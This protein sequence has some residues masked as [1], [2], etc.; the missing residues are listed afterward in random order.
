MNEI[1]NHAWVLPRPGST[2]IGSFPLHFEDKLLKLLKINPEHHKILHPFGGKAK[3]GIRVD[4]NATVEPDYIC[5]AQELPFDDEEFDCIICLDGNSEITLSNGKCCKIKNVKVGD[6]VISDSNEIGSVTNVYKR[7][8]SGK[9]TKLKIKGDFREII[10]TEKHKFL[11]IKGDNLYC[12]DKTGKKSRQ[13]VKRKLIEQ[14]FKPQ[15]IESKDLIIGDYLLSPINSKLINEIYQIKVSNFI[16]QSNYHNVSKLLPESIKVN[17]SFMR[18]IGYYCAEGDSGKYR[19]GFTFNINEK[20]YQKEI[21]RLTKEIYNLD[22][23]V[24]DNPISNSTYIKISSVNLSRFIQ[25]LVPNKSPHRKL[26]PLFLTLHPT[27]QFELLQCWLNGDGGIWINNIN[28]NKVKVT[29]TTTSYK[30]ANDMLFIAKRIG[31]TPLFKKRNNKYK[32][33]LHIVYDV[34]FCGEDCNTLGYNYKQS[35][36]KTSTRISINDYILSPVK[37][38]EKIDV[39]NLLVYNLS[40]TPITQYTVNG[41]I[42]KNCDPP[43]SEEYA[44]R[45]YGVVNPKF[46]KYTQEAVRVLKEYGYLVMY[47]YNATPAIPK[48]VLVKRIFM[49]TRVWHK[50]RCIH[51][52][53]K[54]TV[55][56][57]K[58]ETNIEEWL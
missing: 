58:N 15:F 16:T 44:Q 35:R 19:I 31:L 23:E 43:Y 9:I 29:G 48:T 42:S 2:Y 54:R 22:C 20:E 28:R 21:I 52:H 27:L 25:K 57:E 7:K 45:L 13:R 11:C 10:S 24:Y 46:K 33:A 4:L 53:Q 40:I 36:R 18:W 34:Y 1:E 51:I 26:H 32:N 30:L 55:D 12:R 5:D 38:I 50:L 17:K 37:N 6:K 14:R 47:H 56:W 3:Y 41:V 49:E 8:Y 39:D